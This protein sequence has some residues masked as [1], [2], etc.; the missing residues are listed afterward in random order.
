MTIYD[1]VLLRT[2]TGR[3]YSCPHVY[4]LWHCCATWNLSWHIPMCFPGFHPQ[5]RRALTSVIISKE[6]QLILNSTDPLRQIFHWVFTL[7]PTFSALGKAGMREGVPMSHCQSYERSVESQPEQ[8]ECGGSG[9]A[10]TQPVTPDCC[11][12]HKRSFARRSWPCVLPYQHTPLTGAVIQ[13]DSS[14]IEMF[15]PEHSSSVRCMMGFHLEV[16]SQERQQWKAC[17]LCTCRVSFETVIIQI[18]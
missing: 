9:G 3:S 15:T 8:T 14:V 11:Q 17:S 18:L 1:A 16:M 4:A 6:E 2:L 7:N 5:H 12:M 13:S 10:V